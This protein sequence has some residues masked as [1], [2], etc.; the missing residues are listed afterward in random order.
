[1][2][3]VCQAIKNTETAHGQWWPDVYLPSHFVAGTPHPEQAFGLS[4][5]ES[6][7]EIFWCAFTYAPDPL[8][9]YLQETD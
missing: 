9:A 7:R 3:R 4:I 1:M 2:P 8:S 5:P 6:E